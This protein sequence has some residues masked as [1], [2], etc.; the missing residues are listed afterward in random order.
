MEKMIIATVPEQVAI[1]F[2]ESYKKKHSMEFRMIPKSI[3]EDVRFW[4]KLVEIDL[5]YI[6][7]VPETILEKEDFAKLVDH[8]VFYRYLPKKYL[9]VEDYKN[10]KENPEHAMNVLR[11]PVEINKHDDF[12]WYALSRSSSWY[13][14]SKID[15]QIV[16]DHLDEDDP[17][18]EI[19]PE[20]W[21]QDLADLIW[22][23]S[24]AIVFFDAIPKKYV[25]AEW[26]ML[27]QLFLKKRY[28]LFGYEYTS[29]K[30]ELLAEYWRNFPNEH[31]VRKALKLEDL[32]KR[33]RNPFG[34]TETFWFGESEKGIDSTPYYKELWLVLK[35]IIENIPELIE[36]FFELYQ[37]N[38]SRQ[39]PD[40]LFKVEWI[41]EDDIWDILVDD[42]C[43]ALR[44]VQNAEYEV[45]RL[46]AEDLAN[47]RYK[48]I[49]DEILSFRDMSDEKVKELIDLIVEEYD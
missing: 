21:A 37:E 31:Q 35:P 24:K 8:E 3:G 25:R 28:P 18:S 42:Y 34:Y 39:L 23:S 38:F 33:C 19:F 9:T 46:E 6:S 47:Q 16:F 22:N 14:A 32:V 26:D 36:E 2:V 49:R 12:I 10:H 29:A 20:L 5:Y 48:E 1:D 45:E 15:A 17:A 41:K 40:E 4:A 44:A 27:M 13:P 11:G 30:P 43:S 7:C